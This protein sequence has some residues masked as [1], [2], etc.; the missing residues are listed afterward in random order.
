MDWLFRQCVQSASTIEAGI[1][2]DLWGVEPSSDDPADVA[3]AN[4]L[5][6]TERITYP[7]PLTS[8]VIII[9]R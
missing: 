5:W 4:V 1:V 2:L 9:R 7:S 3:A 8:P 6:K